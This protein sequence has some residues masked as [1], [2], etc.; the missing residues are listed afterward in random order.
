MMTKQL[1]QGGSETDGSNVVILGYTHPISFRGGKTR[2]GS[3]TLGGLVFLQLI[4]GGKSLTK[5]V[6]LR[7]S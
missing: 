6:R 1:T 4:W 3:Q 7:G 5:T 2:Q